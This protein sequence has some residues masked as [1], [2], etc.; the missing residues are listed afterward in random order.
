MCALIRCECRQVG[1]EVFKV[2]DL[3]LDP[4]SMRATRAG[5]ELQLLLIG[6][7]LLII[8]MRESLRVVTR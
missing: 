1:L 3:V 2:V 5:I 8:L 6:L 4:V 7:C